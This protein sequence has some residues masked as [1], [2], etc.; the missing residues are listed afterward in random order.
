MKMYEVIKEAE[1]KGFGS[2]WASDMAKVPG[3]LYKLGKDAAKDFVDPESYKRDYEAVKRG[4]KFLARDPRGALRYAGQ[5]IDDFTGQLANRATFGLADKAQAGLNA[6]TGYDTSRMGKVEKIKEPTDYEKEKEKQYDR[7][8]AAQDRSPTATK[9]G[10]VAGTLLSPPF[11]A[12]AKVANVVGGKVIPKAI[13][14][15]FD[16]IAGQTAKNIAKGI[17]A[18]PSK[19]ATDFAGGIAAQKAAERGVKK[20][21][22]YDPYV[23][24]P[25]FETEYREINRLKNL[26]NYNR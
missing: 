23:S 5:S 17:V 10:D 25:V 4:A 9:A 2:E 6:L 11:L 14:K 8:A 22:P 12:G 7:A 3:D 16:P 19:V 26:I 20:V 1:E 18:I 13:Q 21:D 15:A 24:D